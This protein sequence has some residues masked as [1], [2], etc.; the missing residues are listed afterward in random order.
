[1]RVVLFC[2]IFKVRRL[3]DL[4]DRPVSYESSAIQ[5]TRIEPILDRLADFDFF[6]IGMLG[7]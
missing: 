5:E 3:A 1:M 4:F 6:E 7:I 2:S